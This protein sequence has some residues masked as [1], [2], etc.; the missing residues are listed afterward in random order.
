LP[1]R[2]GRL[3]ILRFGDQAG[4]LIFRRVVRERSGSGSGR[5]QT[6][7]RVLSAAV[8]WIINLVDRQVEVY[9]DP[10]RGRYRSGQIPKPGQEV[11][12]VIDGAV[13]GSIAVADILP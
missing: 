8:Y 2:S 4:Q 1:V 12:L 6:S 11:P 5:G 3:T 7:F 13:T 10:R 9:S